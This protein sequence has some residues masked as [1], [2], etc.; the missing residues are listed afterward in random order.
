MLNDLRFAARMLA[1]SPGF[2]LAAV[3]VLTLG[4]GATTTMFGA[5]NSVLL[6]PLPYPDASRLFVLRETRAVP[7]FE[8]TVLATSEYLDWTRNSRVIQDAAIVA[9]PGL[10]VAVG[11]APPD[12]LAALQV[13]AEFFRLFGIAPAAGRTFGRD[14]ELPGHGDVLLISYRIWQDRFA[15]AS[16]VT[17]RTVRVEGRPSTIIGVLPAKFSFLMRVDLV[18]PMTLTPELAAQA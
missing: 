2:T 5:T 13:S 1:R 11:A 9:Y 16:D 17:G 3:V 6:Q 7:G 18:V 10:A 8:R 15:G 4:I 12:R 14:A